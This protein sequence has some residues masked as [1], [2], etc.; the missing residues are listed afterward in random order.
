MEIVDIVDNNN[1]IIGSATKEE[2]HDKGLLHRTVI[3]EVVNSQ[4]EW[5]L[6]K[7]ASDKQDAGQYVSPVGG[8]VRSGETVEQALEREAMEE[9]GIKPERTEFVGKAIFDRQ[10]RGKRENHL[11]IVY[12]IYSDDEPRLNEESTEYRRF[13]EKEIGELLKKDGKMFG[14]AYHFVVENFF[15]KLATQ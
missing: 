8:H 6:V 9:V 3:A 11:F 1:R 12:I 13:S 2:A 14:D 15:P 4:G 5:I 10:T 7:Q